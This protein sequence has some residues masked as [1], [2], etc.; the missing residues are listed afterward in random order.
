[1]LGHF[2]SFFFPPVVWMTRNV[3]AQYL[4]GQWDCHKPRAKRTERF[5]DRFLINVGHRPRGGRL[6]S[7]PSL[8]ILMRSSRRLKANLLTSE[9]N[10]E[11]GNR[12][13]AVQTWTFAQ[14]LCPPPS[15]QGKCPRASKVAKV[16]V[17]RWNKPNR[18]K[19]N[20]GAGDFPIISLLRF[21]MKFRGRYCVKPHFL[22]I[23]AMAKGRQGAYF[24]TGC[25]SLLSYLWINPF[26]RW[27]RLNKIKIRQSRTDTEKHCVLDKVIK[28]R[29]RKRKKKNTVF[30][31]V[32]LCRC[33][34][35]QLKRRK[36]IQRSLCAVPQM[37]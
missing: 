34:G 18:T 26:I 15:P 37:K 22:H 2:K 25:I 29:G 19:Q 3:R 17:S 13:L 6:S 14:D 5:N 10:C 27:I 21:E 31:R 24:E 36:W 7:H 20:W 28:K 33:R 12:E 11:W 9:R 16:P 30:W 8:V 4:G 1:M 23:G 35:S 32:L